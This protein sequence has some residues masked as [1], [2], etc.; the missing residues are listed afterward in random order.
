MSIDLHKTPFTEIATLSPLLH[1]VHCFQKVFEI[2]SDTAPAYNPDD[3]S[4]FE[5]LTPQEVIDRYD[6][7]EIGKEDIPEV[8]KLC[9]MS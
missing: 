9:Y 2:K 6:I 5:W 1:K 3:F 8:I 4:S 7:G